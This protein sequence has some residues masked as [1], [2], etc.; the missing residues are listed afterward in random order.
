MA[1]CDNLPTLTDIELLKT[2]L[3]NVNTFVNGNAAATFTN[4]NN[5]VISSMSAIQAITRNDAD[6]IV[7]QPYT[8]ALTR[9][10]H[11]KNNEFLTLADFPSA[12]DAQNAAIAS[13]KKIYIPHGDHT[14]VLTGIK[15]RYF[16]GAGRIVDTANNL[17]LTP[18]RMGRQAEYAAVLSAPSAALTRYTLTRQ[19]TGANNVMQDFAEDPYTG[20]L[21]TLHVTGTP[22]LAVINIFDSSGSKT[23][24]STH[25]NATPTNIIGHQGLD[26]A[27]DRAGQRWFVC[28]ANEADTNYADYG[29]LF[30]LAKG[31]G[32]AVTISNKR[33]VKLFNGASGN[34]TTAISLDGRYLIAEASTDTSC[35]IR[36]FNLQPILAA[37]AGDYSNDYISEFTFLLTPNQPI[38]S[39][40][41]DGEHIYVFTGYGLA[42]STDL[43]VYIHRVDGSFVETVFNFEVGKAQALTDGTG[44]YYEMEGA[45]WTWIGGKP[46][47]SCAIASGNSGAR[48]N[49]VYT[50]GGN[51]THTI[52]GRGDT[53]ALVIQG[54][55][56]IAVP[57]SETLRIGH[58]NEQTGLFRDGFTISSPGVVGFGFGNS[59]TWTGTLADAETGGNVSTTTAVGTFQRV[60]NLVYLRISFSNISTTGMTGANNLYIRGAALSPTLAEGSLFTLATSA[61]GGVGSV[62]FNNVSLTAGT[63]QLTPQVSTTGVI[64]LNEYYTAATNAIANVNQFTAATLTISL[65]FSV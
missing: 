64:T 50:L 58:Y 22:D 47:L 6:I 46:F 15:Q 12:L 18:M 56:D 20:E 9:S 35:T 14:G 17:Q 42:T 45:G 4:T 65:I 25:F 49:R 61:F 63:V 1:N 23:Q 51:F 27:W 28:A 59:G 5:E 34:C 37:G 16:Y 2:N 7:Q 43:R 53:P 8:N 55:N 40:A 3:T 13:G 19:G 32:T 44:A 48:I 30:Q 39:L 36:V 29:V 11:D 24:T 57:A 10:Q 41:C 38:Q 26:I 21:F 62:H 31:A 33:L 54:V 52:H 60:G